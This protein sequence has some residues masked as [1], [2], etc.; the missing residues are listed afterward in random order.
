MEDHIQKITKAK[1][2]G[3]VVQVIALLPSKSKALNL[4]LSITKKQNFQSMTNT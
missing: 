3:G 1:R 4:N 2:A